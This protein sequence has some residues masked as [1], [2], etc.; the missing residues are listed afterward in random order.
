MGSVKALSCLYDGSSFSVS[1]TSS[2]FG[3]KGRK[4]NSW[5]MEGCCVAG[6]TGVTTLDKAG[7]VVRDERGL[8]FDLGLEGA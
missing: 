5:G 4:A 1:G 6:W 7:V 3:G 2:T 8:F